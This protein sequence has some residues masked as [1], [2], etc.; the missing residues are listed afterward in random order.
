MDTTTVTKATKE[1]PHTCG[2][3]GAS[4]CADG[5]VLN[6]CGRCKA[7]FYCSTDC[8]RKHWP[9]HKLGCKKKESADNINP[10]PKGTFSKNAPFKSV[11]MEDH[12]PKP[13]PNQFIYWKGMGWMATPLPNMRFKGEPLAI[14][15]LEQFQRPDWIYITV[16]EAVGLP[17]RMLSIV[18][19]DHS[20]S[21]PNALKELFGLDPDPKSPS[22]GQ[23]HWASTPLANGTV[24]L[25]RQDRKLLHDKQVIA[26]IHYLADCNDKL[27][28]MR[29]KESAGEHVDRE[30]IATRLFNPLE[31]K[32][33]FEKMKNAGM[34][35]PDSKEWESTELP[36]DE[37]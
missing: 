26:L 30:D 3:C 29:R 31:F 17:L 32:K 10:D 35:E 23:S 22:F 13:G 5:K 4:K 24:L 28:E 2:S 18:K 34:K 20:D 33:F 15:P 7:Q 16:S 21:L 11:T 25:M 8:Q 9:V 27:T 36:G 37:H 6:C 14:I 1:S 19:Y 12:T